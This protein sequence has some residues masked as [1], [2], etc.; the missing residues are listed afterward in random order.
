MSPP[1][2]AVDNTK[3]NPDMEKKSRWHV[4]VTA[5]LGAVVAVLAYTVW[6]IRLTIEIPVLRGAVVAFDSDVCPP[7][8]EEAKE[9]AGRVVVGSGFGEGLTPRKRKETGGEERVELDQAQIP[10]HNHYVRLP[11]RTLLPNLTGTNDKYNVAVDI[12]LAQTMRAGGGE[13]HNNMPP[14]VVQLYCRKK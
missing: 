2:L 11:T 13:S 5:V 10:E 14:Y 12:E 3:A 7:G 6:S 4:A 8:W 1:E 9:L